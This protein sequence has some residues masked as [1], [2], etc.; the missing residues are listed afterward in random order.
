LA[1]AANEEL[2]GDAALPANV[3]LAFKDEEHAI[4]GLALFEEDVSRL[5]DDLLSVPGEPEAI[6][7]R[8]TLQRRNAIERSRDGFD[9]GRTGRRG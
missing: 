6:F 8:Q 1:S 4:R 7:K 5:R 3:Y 9:W 2:H